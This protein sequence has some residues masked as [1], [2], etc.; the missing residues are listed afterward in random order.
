MPWKHSCSWIQRK[1]Y[2]HWILMRLWY[3]ITCYTLRFGYGLGIASLHSTSSTFIG[4]QRFNGKSIANIHKAIER[5][6]GCEHVYGWSWLRC[7][8]TQS[9]VFSSYRRKNDNKSYSID[10]ILTWSLIIFT[11]FCYM[12]ILLYSQR[13]MNSVFDCAVLPRILLVQFHS[14]AKA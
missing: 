11:L 7:L 13:N 4:D 8:Y 12:Y 3:R 2:T 10:A 6:V 9:I 1:A 5:I 14:L